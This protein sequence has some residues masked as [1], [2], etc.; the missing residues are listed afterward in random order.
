MF[1]PGWGLH[2]TDV[3]IALANLVAVV[4]KQAQAYLKNG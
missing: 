4:G 3:N 1:G 2:G